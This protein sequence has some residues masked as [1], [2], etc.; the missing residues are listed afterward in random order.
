MGIGANT[1]VGVLGGI[2]IGPCG[3]RVTVVS[4]DMWR[5][6]AGSINRQNLPSAV[7]SLRLKSKTLAC[8]FLN[9]PLQ[10]PRPGPP[11]KRAAAGPRFSLGGT[12]DR[13]RE[14]TWRLGNAARFLDA[15][16]QK[17]GS[18]AQDVFSS[19]RPA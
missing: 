4:H 15:M 7:S 10:N 13:G 11:E 2:V 3:F 17:G 8:N 6:P 19:Q 5:W 18:H 12:I 9:P 1:E 16:P 14:R